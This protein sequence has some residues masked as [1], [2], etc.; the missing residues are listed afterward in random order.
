MNLIKN[1]HQN[2]SLSCLNGQ[3]M[4]QSNIHQMF[5]SSEVVG[6]GTSAAA[7]VAPDVLAAS[8]PIEEGGGGTSPEGVPIGSKGSTLR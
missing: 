7:A 1:I 6:G 4:I 2:L 3:D 5:E 8:A